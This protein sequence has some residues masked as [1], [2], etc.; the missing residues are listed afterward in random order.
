MWL[1]TQDLSRISIS[2]A[3]ADTEFLSTHKSTHNHC[4][5]VQNFTFSMLVFLLE[6]LHDLL[7]FLIRWTLLKALH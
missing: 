2:W 7:L 5:G 4:V 6:N 1:G 3:V